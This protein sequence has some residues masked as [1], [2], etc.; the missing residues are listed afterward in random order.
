MVSN[1]RNAI[2]QMRRAIGEKDF[3]LE[4]SDAPVV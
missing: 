2:E 4:I 3:D 1:S